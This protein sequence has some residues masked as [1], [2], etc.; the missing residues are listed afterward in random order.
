MKIF[1]IGWAKTGS[2]TLGE[3]L[4]ALGYIH[5]SQALDLV[6]DIADGNMS[7]IHSVAKNKDSFDDWPWIILYVELDQMFPS[8]KFILTERSTQ[9][10]EASAELNRIR[11]IL[12]GLP[13][14]NVTETELIGRYEKH[15]HDVKSYFLHRPEDLLVCNWEKGDGWDCLCKFL[16]KPVPL[17]NFPHANKGHYR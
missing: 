11:Q 5:Q 13:F 2:T 12:Y 9:N 4:K 1:G 10:W 17:I 3:C 8:S 15:C 6:G 16:N 14:P 7:R